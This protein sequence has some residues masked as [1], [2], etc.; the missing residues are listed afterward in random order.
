MC[1][2]WTSEITRRSD[3]PNCPTIQWKN[4]FRIDLIVANKG[5]WIGWKS[6][7]VLCFS[8]FTG[9][10]PCDEKHI[11]TWYFREFSTISQS[12]EMILEWQMRSASQ[13]APKIA[14]TRVPAIMYRIFTLFNF[15]VNSKMYKPS[16]SLTIWN[17]GKHQSRMKTSRDFDWRSAKC[18]LSTDKRKHLQSKNIN[19][20]I[21][22]NA[23]LRTIISVSEITI[24]IA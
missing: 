18:T 4:G 6:A 14:A 10:C 17:C 21:Y 19:A 20:S 12:I 23:M 11:R 5:V 16:A 7:H 24:V 9:I 1:S 3:S 8:Y 22:D 2:E 15:N 13:N